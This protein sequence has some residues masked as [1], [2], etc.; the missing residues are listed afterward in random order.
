MNILSKDQVQ[1]AVEKIFVELDR[2]TLLGAALDCI[3]D[4]GKL[5][6]RTKFEAIIAEAVE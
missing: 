6:L 1:R 2:S 5:K 3:S 4:Q